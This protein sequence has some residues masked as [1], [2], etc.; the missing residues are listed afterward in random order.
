MFL[1]LL[2]KIILKTIALQS[3]PTH[4]LP[5]GFPVRLQLL[6]FSRELIYGVLFREISTFFHCQKRWSQKV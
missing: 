3:F 6:F 5:T 4:G 2:R 1:K